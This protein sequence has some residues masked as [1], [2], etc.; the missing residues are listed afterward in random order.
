MLAVRITLAHFSVAFGDQ[1]SELRCRKRHGCATKLDDPCL[2]HRVRKAGVHFGVQLV[3]DRRRS[4]L[5]S[6]DPAKATVSNPGMVSATAGTSGK[7]S[8]RAGEL[9]PSARRLPVLM[10]SMDDGRLS[11]M[12]CTCPA[13]RSVSAAGAPR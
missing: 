1:L 9:T 12:T 5:G 3:D 11:N 6:A 10:Y 4:I 13:N 2:N 7:A 8:S